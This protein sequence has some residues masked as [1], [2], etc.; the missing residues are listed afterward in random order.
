MLTVS[1]ALSIKSGKAQELTKHKPFGP[2]VNIPDLMNLSQDSFQL[3]ES[4]GCDCPLSFFK[5]FL[6]DIS[7]TQN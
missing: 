4:G 7:I 2:G 6:D 3:G 1:S 5:G